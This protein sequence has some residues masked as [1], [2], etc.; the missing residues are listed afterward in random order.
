MI[1]RLPLIYV[2]LWALGSGQVCMAIDSESLQDPVL[3]TRY[4]HIIAELR[5]LVC[6]NQSIQDS[7]AQLAKDLRRQVRKLLREGKSDNEI[8]DFMVARYGDFVRYRPPLKSST[9]VLWLGP[10]L[11]A[12]LGVFMLIGTL[13][14]H[15]GGADEVE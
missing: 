13:R 14:R 11:I 8:L 4:T 12:I 10:V 5:C 6:Q 7:D 3:Q 9:L 2:V 15:L 1:K